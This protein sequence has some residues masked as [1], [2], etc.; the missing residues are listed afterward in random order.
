MKTCLNLKKMC[1]KITLRP[2][3]IT[4]VYNTTQNNKSTCCVDSVFIVF[5]HLHVLI[6]ISIEDNEQDDD[7]N[8]MVHISVMHY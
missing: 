8:G 5:I 3:T 4:K 1:K 2:T 7:D 6:F